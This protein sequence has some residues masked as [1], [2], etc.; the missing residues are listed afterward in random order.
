MTYNIRIGT[1]N[2]GAGWADYENMVAGNEDEKKKLKEKIDS[3]NPKWD[4]YQTIKDQLQDK[5]EE[6]VAQKLANNFDIISL[7]EIKKLDRKFVKTLE[8]KGFSIYC[9]DNVLETNNPEL[10][11]LLKNQ[12]SHS[13]PSWL[14]FGNKKVEPQ[15]DTAIA[16][17]TSL[18]EKVQNLSIKS[19]SYPD[20]EI[21]YGQEIAAVV[22]KI[23]DT[24]IDLAIASMH[25]WGFPL[26]PKEV[27]KSDK[28]LY[29][30]YDYENMS[31]ATTY[32]AEAIKTVKE[33]NATISLIA[34]DLNNN[35][36][37]Y[38]K[39]FKLIE[40]NGFDI[41]EPDQE[42]NVNRFDEDYKFRKIDF[43][44]T[45]NKNFHSL[46]WRIWNSIVSF[47]FSTTIVSFEKAKVLDD[48]DFT[49]EKNCSDHKPVG[50][51]IHIETK[52]ST[53]KRMMKCFLSI[54]SK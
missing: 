54:F 6:V 35:P 24:N 27:D 40:K 8:E 12:F 2:I 3:F 15:I 23:K 22:A 52:E 49:M 1:F 32:M 5:I 10:A 13:G 36:D 19:E 34:G 20:E 46:L 26:Y 53:L 48:F 21:P 44:F 17:R 39:P 16:V 4:T 33:Q 37:N 47:F 38:D 9:Q 7:Q 30:K 18:F 29:N 42:T 28:S 31:Y 45:P 50:T 25:S 43:I 11:Q 51:V 41:L 14:S